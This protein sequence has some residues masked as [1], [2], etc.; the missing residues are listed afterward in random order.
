MAQTDVKTTAPTT[1]SI[2]LSKLPEKFRK[3]PSLILGV[4]KKAEEAAAYTKKHD[5]AVR[6]AL[7]ILKKAHDPEYQGYLAIELKR[8]GI[9]P[10]K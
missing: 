2:D 3:D 5:E 1:I 7:S 9:T 6:K 10:K 8:V 4:V